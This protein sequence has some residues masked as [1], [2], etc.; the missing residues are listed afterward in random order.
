VRALLSRAPADAAAEDALAA[1]CTGLSAAELEWLRCSGVLAPAALV[2]MQKIDRTLAHGVFSP[3]EHAAEVA[4]VVSELI[5]AAAVGL[6]G[7]EAEAARL[8]TAADDAEALRIVALEARRKLDADASA[9]QDALSKLKLALEDSVFVAASATERAAQKCATA[10]ATAVQIAQLQAWELFDALKP[11]TDEDAARAEAAAWARN[12]AAA[13]AAAKLQE[14]QERAAEAEALAAARARAA[15]VAAAAAVEGARAAEAEMR[16]Q[17]ERKRIAAEKAAADA[18]R[19]R[20]A[21]AAVQM[22]EAERAAANARSKLRGEEAAVLEREA[23]D[24]KRSAARRSSRDAGCEAARAAPAPA[25][26]TGAAPRPR[27]TPRA[28]CAGRARRLRCARS[29]TAA[30]SRSGRGG[31]VCAFA[32][33]AALR[34]MAAHA[35]Q[36][37]AGSGSRLRAPCAERMLWPA[38][39]RET[40][41]NGRVRAAATTALSV[42][43]SRARCVIAVLRVAGATAAVRA[44]RHQQRRALRP[45]T[46][47]A[48]TRSSG[49]RRLLLL[50]RRRRVPR[51]LRVA[52][53]HHGVQLAL[54]GRAARLRQRVRRHDAFLRRHTAAAVRRLPRPQR[55]EPHADARGQAAHAQPRRRKVVRAP[56]EGAPDGAPRGERDCERTAVERQQRRRRPCAAALPLCARR[57]SSRRAGDAG[58]L[59][60]SAAVQ[61]CV[62]RWPSSSSAEVSATC[63]AALALRSPW[64]A[65]E[66]HQHAAV[67]HVV[68]HLQHHARLRGAAP[69]KTPQRSD[70]SCAALRHAASAARRL[71]ARWHGRA[72]ATF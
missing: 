72:P 59:R 65:W 13:A 63:A 10:G 26:G 27:R 18:A 61:G 55:E 48:A 29:K 66:H 56:Q 70:A 47:A 17:A 21:A 38:R 64:R 9:L 14:A 24:A 69:A 57:S 19:E 23:A 8:A 52:L 3:A 45:V 60:A 36:T 54:H 40:G 42:S 28:P 6:I 16:E 53:R 50:C 43:I 34:A 30:S 12:E 7:Q 22:A 62:L 31:A 41:P 11:R 35:T 1:R 58:A 5:V 4:V 49:R 68:L 25:A 33:W 44:L 51:P 15:R 32:R 71:A 2:R 20:D 37:R 39:I 67:R 46:T